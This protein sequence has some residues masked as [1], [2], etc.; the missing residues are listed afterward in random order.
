MF[1]FYRY[2]NG[3]F[4]ITITIGG[5]VF[6]IDVLVDIPFYIHNTRFDRSYKRLLPETVTAKSRTGH[7]TATVTCERVQRLQYIRVVITRMTDD[8]PY[9]KLQ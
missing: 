5:L 7:Q 3:G 1:S 9:D 4:R 6:A 2:P 8:A